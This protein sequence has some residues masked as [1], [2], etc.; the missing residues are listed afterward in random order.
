MLSGMPTARP[1]LVPVLLAAALLAGCAP[2]PPAPSAT[3]KAPAAA[4]PPTPTPTPTPTV[5]A[6]PAPAPVFGGDCGNVFTDAEVTAALGVPVTAVVRDRVV[7]PLTMAVEQLGGLHCT[8][9]AVD[10][11]SAE[12]W[13]TVLPAWA[14]S[15]GGL[16]QLSCYGPCSFGTAA[17]GLW[18]AGVV[19]P[20]AE[21]SEEESSSAVAALA[22]TFA[23]SAARQPAPAD[24]PPPAAGQWATPADCQQLSDAAG[25]PA[26]LNDPTLEASPGNFPG[27]AG[28]GAYAAAQ[29]AGA[30]T[31]YFTSRD[32]SGTRGPLSVDLQILPGAGWVQSQVERLPQSTAVAVAGADAAFVVTTPYGSS[33]YEVLHVFAAGNWM[34]VMPN[35][36]TVT[37]DDV[38][39]VVPALLAALARD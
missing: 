27:E 28:P 2:T 32:E 7:L 4:T 10:D 30:M 8:W 33:S 9:A 29:S 17:N 18:L 12:S 11:P 3:T 36:T 1:L 21:P 13:F 38:L 20:S 39:G 5:A 31:C 16:D 34:T 35:S 15:A 19:Y 22:A 14:G 6:A 26:A 37:I 24:A 23:S 25:V